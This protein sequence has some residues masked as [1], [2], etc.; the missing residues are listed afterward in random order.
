[1]IYNWSISKDEFLHINNQKEMQTKATKSYHY[2]TKRMAKIKK[3]NHIKYEQGHE[4]NH[5]F[6][7]CWFKCKM[8]E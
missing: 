4:T 1:M 8:A 3:T 5:N 2:R 6:I 7:H